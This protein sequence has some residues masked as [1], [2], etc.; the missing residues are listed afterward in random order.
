MT[1]PRYQEVTAE[2]IPSVTEDGVAVRVVAGQVWG[3]PGPVTEIAAR[4]LYLDVSLS[5]GASFVQPVPAGHTALA[6]LIEGGGRFGADAEPIEATRLAV[7]DD[8]D[9]VEVQTEAGVRFLFIAGAPFG[10]P[11]MPYGPFV[12]NTVEEIQQALL[13]LQQGTFIQP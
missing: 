9:Q 4:P 7:F 11:I 1:A 2:T 10:E 3:T 12:M 8:G 13:E 6:Y 5:P